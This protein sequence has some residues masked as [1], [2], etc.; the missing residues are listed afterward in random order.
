MSNPAETVARDARAAYQAS[1]L[2]DSSER[3]SALLKIRQIL[4]DNKDDVLS[5]NQKDLD[6]A[7]PLVES[8][9][10][11]KSMFSRLSLQSSSKFDSMLQGILDVA[12]LPCPTDQ[13]TY[14]KELDDGLELYRVTCPIGVLLVIFEARP[15]V[16]VNI[17]S[18][19]LKSGNAAILKPGKETLHTTSI[20]SQ[21][22]QK[23]L[24]ST[25]FP[26]TFIQTVSTR[27]E[28]STLLSQDKFID[29]VMPRGG[30]E[31]VRSIKGQTKI[32]VMGHADGLCHAYLDESADAAK[33]ER[34]VL[35]SKL[36]YPAACNAL[37]TLLIHRSLLTSLWP[38]LS[39]NLLSN[40]ITLY[41][42]ESTREHL[43][44]SVLASH[45]SQIH[46]SIPE[47]YYIEHLSPTLSVKTVDN[48]TE[49]I[50]HIAEHG[51]KHTETIVTENEVIAKAF[52]RGCDAAG[53]Y[54]NASTRFA[55]GFRYGFGTEVGI[56]TGKTHARGPV[57]LE[58]LCIYKYLA[59]SKADNGHVSLD[60]GSAEEGKKVYTHKTIENPT[61]PF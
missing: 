52:M 28:I 11:S 61:L 43:H 23:A 7:S 50:N 55:D 41:L 32:P 51:S 54:W 2:I 46:S 33:A 57:G 36:S 47:T 9:N 58:G 16:V 56:S 45:T 8:G 15:E 48:V 1:Q 60:F 14:A 40:N 6:A 34:V 27:S 38:T 49:A 13:I 59:R 37:E 21:L 3:D 10:I 53:V 42:D 26:P 4:I 17:A 5:A 44:S 19:A 18:L 31:L 29:L 20:L 12:Q 30:A 39:A 25:P 22:I 24:S 35:D